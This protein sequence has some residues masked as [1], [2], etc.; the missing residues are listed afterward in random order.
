MKVVVIGAGPCGI[1]SSIEIKKNNPSYE[2]VLLEKEIKG[3]GSR[4][5][6][7][8]NGRCNL[9]N[10]N[11]NPKNYNNSKFVFLQTFFYFKIQLNPASITSL[12]S[13][14]N[15]SGSAFINKR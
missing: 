12:Q 9:G 3:I 1:M 2:V 8:G 6:V 14:C 4:I 7:S 13:F 15:F 11:I 10:V 5:K